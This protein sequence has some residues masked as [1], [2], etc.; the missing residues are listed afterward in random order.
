MST[1]FSQS[2]NVTNLDFVDIKQSLIDYFK[3]ND[4]PF[5][6]WDYTGSGLNT[7]MDVLAHN[8]HYNAV[9]AH[10]AVNE[11]FIDSAQLRQNVVSAAKLIGYTP[12]SYTAP[13]AKVNLYVNSS[14]SSIDSYVI[15]A[16][17]NFSSNFPIPRQSATYNFI[18]L[19][20]IVCTRNQTSGLLEAVDQDIHQGSIQ[21]RRVQINSAE[22]KNEYVISD[23][24]I[25]LRT[26]NV[27]VYQNSRQDIGE[28]YTKFTDVTDVN[29]DTPIY[30][31]YENYSGNYVVSFGNGVFGKKPDNLNILELRYLVTSGDAANTSNKFTYNGGFNN[32]ISSVSVQTSSPAYGGSTNES[33]GSIKYNAPLQ[34]IAQNRA[35]TAD[36]YKTLVQSKFAV[37]SM[38]VWGGE[39]NNPPQYGKVF[40]SI[41][42]SDDEN[43]IFLSSAE[44]EEIL[45]YLSGKK[46]LSILP[47]IVDP[48]YINIVLDV[49]FKYNRNLTAFTVTELQ[50]K[51]KE[52]IVAFSDNNLE[53]FDGVFRHSQLV[54]AVDNTSPA[55]LNSLVRVF[56]SKTFTVAASDPK[57]LTIEYGT[58]LTIDDGLAIVKSTGWVSGGV[59]YYM[60][61]A[62]HAKDSNLRRLYS[63]YID[64]NNNAIVGE[65]NIGTLT[66]STGTLSLNAF[67]VDG[68]TS[69]TID[70]LPKSNDIVSR[71]N[72]LIRIDT[73]S[74]NVYGEVDTIAIGG[75]SK[76]IDY[77][78]FSRDR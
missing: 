56:V 34:Y 30:F 49:L 52:T 60:G 26:L 28:V 16:G 74:I 32:Q 33:I 70:L 51:I 6:D 22:D 76:S 54:R 15:S 72:Q 3:S 29:G 78:T 25:D 14:D 13:K 39:E 1:Q 47:E 45:Q 46:V 59:L 71:R 57:N 53:S 31:I 19:T 50:D 55:I 4:S 41:K 7:L 66:L 58:A 63:Y 65:S 9:L 27:V 38:A 21:T 17:T 77:N 64:S 62:P 8:T 37:R 2:V 11:S 12:N 40:M 24:N 67:G 73:P 35:V 20:D 61:D 69:I 10:M 75:S 5:K 23:K 43:D 44:K 36:D 18:N 48:E 68:D 42:K